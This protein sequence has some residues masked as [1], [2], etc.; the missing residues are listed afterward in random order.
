VFGQPLVG[1]GT[2]HPGLVDQQHGARGEGLAAV[3]VGEQPRG[4]Q[5]ADAGL[6]LEGASG[7]VGR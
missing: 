4:V 6:L 3:E 7:E 5:R 2:D 1:A